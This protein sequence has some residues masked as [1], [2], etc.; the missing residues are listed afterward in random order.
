MASAQLQLLAP[1]ALS[2]AAAPAPSVHAAIVE[3]IKQGLESP[4]AAVRGRAMGTARSL[5]QLGLSQAAGSTAEATLRAYLSSLL[6]PTVT[7][8]RGAA[9]PSA[10]VP[11]AD[12]ADNKLAVS[13]G[14]N[15]LL[16]LFKAANGNGEGAS[17]VCYCVCVCVCG[18]DCVCWGCLV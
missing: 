1:L 5:A 15:L 18:C 2:S 14:I 8:L 7:L 16:V 11:D 12:D 13:E 9:R 4:H 6:A 3:A 17:C 10:G